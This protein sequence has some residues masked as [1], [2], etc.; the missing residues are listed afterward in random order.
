MAPMAS[1][2]DCTLID[3]ALAG[4][5]ECFSALMDRHT[6]AVRR[7]VRSMVRNTSD[8]DDVVQETF[9]KAWRHLSSFRSDSSFRTW[10]ISVATNEAL[11]QYRR[12]RNNPVNPTAAD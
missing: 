8:Q 6:A 1:L 9:I 10:I 2:Q 12:Q 7:R 4:E 11:Q 5:V 3:R